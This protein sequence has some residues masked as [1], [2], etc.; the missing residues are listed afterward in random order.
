MI[1]LKVYIP[2]PLNPPLPGERG[3]YLAVFQAPPSPGEGFGER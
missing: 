2:H 3:T 1:F